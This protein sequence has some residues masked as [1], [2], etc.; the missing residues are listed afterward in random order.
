M[1][2][3]QGGR[4]YIFDKNN[5]SA[6]QTP[7]PNEIVRFYVGS[8]AVISGL[9]PS[10]NYLVEEQ[11][12]GAHFTAAN[13]SNNVSLQGGG[14]VNVTVTN[15]YEHGT[16]NLIIRKKLE[17]L[18]AE[19]NVDGDTK[20]YVR[21]KD[22]DDKN[23]LL[24][25][26]NES[27]G[28][29]HA[30][31]NS[32]SS[33]PGT[34]SDELVTLT[35][36][37]PAILTGLWA[38]HEY[39][40]EEDAGA[41]YRIEYEG[42]NQ[43]FPESGNMNVTVI[44]TYEQGK[45]RLVISKKLAG[46]PGD[47]GVNENTEFWVRVKELP[48]GNYVLFDLQPD[49]GYKANGNSES[50][51]PTGD[52]RE[53]VRITARRSY[54]FRNLEPGCEYMVEEVGGARYTAA[55]AGNNTRLL[56][57]SNMN[58]VIT[59]TFEPEKPGTTTN[60]N[61]PGKGSLVISKRL[62]GRPGDWGVDGDTVFA[63]RVKDIT[64]GKYVLLTLQPD[65][66]YL[67]VGK[68]NSGTQTNDSRELAQL[69]SGNPITI[70]GL[71]SNCVYA[72]EEAG[73]AHYTAAYAGNDVMLQDGSVI[74]VTITNT[75]GRDGDGGGDDGG[76]GDDNG[77]DKGR[78]VIRKANFDKTPAKPH[79]V[80][81]FFVKKNGDPVDLTAVG[82]RI[83]K[84]GGSGEYVAA[85][86]RK[87]SFTLTYDTE[88]TIDGL[89]LGK[90]TVAEYAVGYI[91]S[92]ELIDKSR[93]ETDGIVITDITVI[94]TNEEID[95]DSPRPDDGSA[96]DYF[97]VEIPL[98]PLAEM[99]SSQGDTEQSSTNKPQPGVP[100]TG[101]GTTSELLFL[102]LVLLLGAAVF[103]YFRIREIKKT[104]D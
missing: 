70:N 103:I 9:N 10:H 56:E 42:N 54:E 63:V 86:L 19:W 75:Y 31:A 96:E 82:V 92:C 87:G 18:P 38:N 36:G 101:I 102:L 27:D 13:S 69:T 66:S 80:F 72:V 58:V 95:G 32:G 76:D 74:N 57:D 26:Y 79:E 91:K 100:I 84:T 35:A 67:A 39:V 81:T 25:K 29:Y 64:N 22:A 30:F 53:L 20:F 71:Q 21:V 7:D 43:K 88:I 62:A 65:G 17:G 55:Y 28:T 52:T 73:G 85:D 97:E 6:S 98:I 60:T 50:K 2:K 33:M 3:H 4:S 90:Y 99:P 40:V 5:S 77:N 59:N 89:P 16:G 34:D 37:Y 93:V 23:Y 104:I 11:G 48:E 45:G 8:P 47:W 61:E 51:T 14:N 24:F 44:N 1:L 15:T 41:Y 12:S 46:S 83:R 49:G 78:L 68:S 94:F